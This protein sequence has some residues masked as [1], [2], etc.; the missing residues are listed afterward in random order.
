MNR[1]A[2]LRAFRVWAMG[3]GVLVAASCSAQPADELVLDTGDEGFVTR[4][5]GLWEAG[6]GAARVAA[7]EDL[8]AFRAQDSTF[9]EQGFRLVDFETWGS[10]D[11][12]LFVGLWHETPAAQR[13]GP[14]AELVVDASLTGIGDLVERYAGRNFRMVDIEIYRSVGGE[15]VVAAVFHPGEGDH[16]F[17]VGLS[18]AALYDEK[19]DLQANGFR[20][21]DV[22]TY[23]DAEGERRNAALWAPAGAA[24]P[25]SDLALAGAWAGVLDVSASLCDRGL[26]DFEYLS[27]PM[28]RG[29][30]WSAVWSAPAREQSV[31]FPILW[32]ELT[33]LVSPP[34][35]SR[36]AGTSPG[37]L[38]DI[39]ILIRIPSG[40]EIESSLGADHDGPLLPGGPGPP[41]QGP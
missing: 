28:A 27:V 18:A 22:E 38:V 1:F 32:E 6:P 24:T 35:A 8:A 19:E 29:L 41:P 21:I 12:R 14:A 39:E 17:R 11:D 33:D 30:G 7:E 26:E 3:C 15:Q 5:G 25:D 9:E 40:A 2:A 16:P 34:P 37:R 23:Y 36:T 20:I 4:Y 13:R 10:A 31:H